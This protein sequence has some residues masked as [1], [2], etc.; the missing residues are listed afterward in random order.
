M[1]RPIALS[2]LLLPVLATA[3]SGTWH[4]EFEE[5]ETI[6][7][8]FKL[9]AGGSAAKLA[10]DTVNGFIHVTGNA[11]AEIQVKVQ[12]H[13]FARSK[14]A[15][16]DARKDV[17]LDMTQQDNVVRLSADG[18][19]RWRGGEDDYGYRVI[20]D[21]EIQVP[22][23]A[24]LDL[25]TLNGAIQVK[26]SSGDFQIRTL[27]GPVEMEEIGGSGSVHT[28][29][30]RVKVAFSRN[31]ARES[32][33]HTLNGAID[34]YFHSTP[35]VDLAWHTLHGGLFADFE[36]TTVPGAIK[37]AG[38]GD[39][40]V[41]RTGGNMKVRAGKGGP[42]LSFHTLNGPIRLHSKGV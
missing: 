33:F 21:C 22:V 2:L 31:P 3:H 15:M 18:P 9:A 6:D 19:F 26:N 29:N 42:E 32:S 36:V 1:K 28:L 14:E 24:A 37:G 5:H 27:N 10:A 34:V 4:W 7:R 23:G 40:L 12:K 16:A 20:F 35:D 39:R 41:Y 8:T 25:H 38:H 11:G 30:G 17:K 13:V